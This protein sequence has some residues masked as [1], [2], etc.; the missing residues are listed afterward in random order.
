MRR[1]QV[2]A[3]ALFIT[4]AALP[5][6]AQSVGRA[7]GTVT[8]QN[9]KPIKGAVVR[10][11]NSSAT[12]SEITSTTDDKGRFGMVGLQLG[13]WSFSADAPGFETSTGTAPVR[14][15]TNQNAALRFAL[16]R[17]PEPIPGALTRNI[18][19][20]LNAA[21]ALRAEGRYDQ[22][23]AAYQQIQSKNAK[24]TTLNL[25]IA[26]TFK[27]KGDRETDGAARQAS[28]DGAVAAYSEVLKSDPGSSAAAEAS[29][30]IQ[31]LKK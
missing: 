25:L 23:L 8:D 26:E 31:N 21:Q 1:L 2:L 4:C 5:A 28:Y 22:A 20:Q 15:N 12:P 14:S 30:Q 19:D 27:Q 13:I 3:A 29:A 18:A 6:F 10:A 9:G 24:L 11:T 17:L 7:V 16:I